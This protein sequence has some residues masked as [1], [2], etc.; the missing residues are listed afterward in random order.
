MQVETVKLQAYK[1]CEPPGNFILLQKAL[2]G[3]IF[4]YILEEYN[5]VENKADYNVTINVENL[6][7][8]KITRN[9]GNTN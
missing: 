1:S 4:I 6:T 7:D 5:S 8:Y 2:V 3:V 9:V